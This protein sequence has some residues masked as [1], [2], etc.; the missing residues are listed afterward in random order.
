LLSTAQPLDDS[1]FAQSLFAHDHDLLTR[2]YHSGPSRNRRICEQY[3]LPLIRQE[4]LDDLL[5]TSRQAVTTSGR[6]SYTSP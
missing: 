6:T 1:L 3:N 2:F 4:Q 5:L